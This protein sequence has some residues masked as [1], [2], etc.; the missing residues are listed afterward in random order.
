MKKFIKILVAVSLIA[1]LMWP[2]FASAQEATPPAADSGSTAQGNEEEEAETANSTS[3]LWN[4]DSEKKVITG[5]DLCITED[6]RTENIITTL[7]EP[8]MSSGDS[9]NT[10]RQC[11][12]LTAKR[13]CSWIGEGEASDKEKAANGSKTYTKEV[14]DTNC[15]KV[16]V[17]KEG[18]ECNGF[19][20]CDRITVILAKSGVGLIEIYIG[21]IYR[22]AASIAGIVCIL[23]MIVSGIQISAAGEDTQAV[24]SAKKRI[25]QSIL[26]LVVLFMSAAILYIVN[27]GF[28]GL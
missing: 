20:A 22:W 18:T 11:M 2:V 7:E 17:C 28:F 16:I 21:K 9:K 8:M 26:G 15:P 19:I 4:C 24:E 23:I 10:I 3:E 25:I 5:Y 13:G 14:Q 1:S 12:R 6:E 27:P